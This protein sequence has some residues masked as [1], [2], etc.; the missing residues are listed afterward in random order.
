[1]QNRL[2][3]IKDH[4]QIVEQR[5]VSGGDIND[6]YYV[7][8]EENEYFV[9]ANIN[10]EPSF[11][12]VE[13]YGLHTIRQTNT[14]H[15]PEVYYYDTVPSQTL[16][17]IMEWIDGEKSA[18]TDEQLGMDLAAMHLTEAPSY[19]GLDRLS[20]VGTLPQE[21]RWYPSW[22]EYY[23]EKR[24]LPQLK[25]G[26]ERGSMPAN[27]RK[28]VEKLLDRIEDYIPEKPPVSLL[29]GDLWAGNWMVGPQGIPYL[30][31]PSIVY[32]DPIFELAMTELFGGFSPVFYRAYQELLPLPDDYEDRKPLY[33]LFYLLVHLNL[34]GETYG[35]SVDRILKRYV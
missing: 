23:R 10:V 4:S 34:F 9:K 28:N 33:Q 16:Y 35:P 13:A 2:K 17:L 19:Y 15:V 22:T 24:L 25:I 12:E 11:F 1:M 31:D 26:L 5:R 7:R 20:F 3:K 21:N 29:H 18:N 14:I 6:A 8:T 30:I 32:G 27:R